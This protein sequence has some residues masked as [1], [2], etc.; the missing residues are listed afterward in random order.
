MLKIGQ[1][2]VIVNYG[3]EI[4][5]ILMIHSGVA[6]QWQL[7]GLEYHPDND[8]SNAIDE[9]CGIKCDLDPCEFKIRNRILYLTYYGT[10][11]KIDHN[12]LDK[13]FRWISLYDL[14]RGKVVVE[15]QSKELIESMFPVIE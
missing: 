6:D 3:E 5:S 8:L 14:H 11:D 4:S 10:V 1:V 15:S 9:A 2:A 7:P 12:T 13:D